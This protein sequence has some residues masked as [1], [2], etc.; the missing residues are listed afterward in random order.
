MKKD[1]KLK[2]N[3]ERKDIVLTEESKTPL[4]VSIIFLTL[5][6]FKP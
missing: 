3:D 4:T 2:A 1:S 6:G 5:E